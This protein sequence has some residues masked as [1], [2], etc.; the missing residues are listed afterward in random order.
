M[1]YSKQPRSRRR[2]LLRDQRGAA[3]AEALI[4]LPVLILI[5]GGNYLLLNAGVAKTTAMN[6]VRRDAWHTA[7]G[8]G[9]DESN[10]C[11]GDCD[12]F[13]GGGGPVSRVMGWIQGL[14]N[15]PLIG[16]IVE[17]FFGVPTTVGANESF[18]VPGAFTGVQNTASAG[19]RIMCNTERKTIR[20]L[21][22]EA[23]CGLI[24]D[25]TGGIPFF[26]TRMCNGS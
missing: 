16:D 20:M 24:R 26:L 7:N 1:S 22:T 15:I 19:Y 4:V 8:S 13:D 10:E 3:Y 6:S 14:A 25:I 9:C 12:T 11:P 17:N 2:S 23:F 18:E 5:M 21:M